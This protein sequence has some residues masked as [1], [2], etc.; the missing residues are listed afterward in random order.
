MLIYRQVFSDSRQ[1]SLGIPLQ[2]FYASLI[3]FSGSGEVG[4]SDY[5]VLFFDNEYILTRM[6][7]E[8]NSDAP[9]LKTLMAEPEPS[10]QREKQDQ[11][12]PVNGK[13]SDVVVTPTPAGPRR[14][15][16]RSGHNSGQV[17]AFRIG[18]AA[19]LPAAG[20]PG[21]SLPFL[22]PTPVPAYSGPR[23]P[24]DTGPPY[25]PS[26]TCRTF[27]LSSSTAKGFCM[28][29]IPFSIT[30]WWAITSAVYPDI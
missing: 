18:S 11:P 13:S 21:R 26:R 9:F 25:C 29:L 15:P 23:F 4:T 16:S 8:K 30:P 1:I 28:K 7:Y 27:L 17:P 24:A 3:K 22:L 19:W 20:W 6:I 12:Y 14:V 10:N 5:L 2:S